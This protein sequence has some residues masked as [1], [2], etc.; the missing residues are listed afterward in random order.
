MY[1]GG[2]RDPRPLIDDDTH[3]LSEIPIPDFDSLLN[4]HDMREFFTPAIK[5]V[6]NGLEKCFEADQ[7][8][9]VALQQQPDV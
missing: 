4:D 3:G 6:L 5:A 7:A 1:N 9:V 8:F 2:E